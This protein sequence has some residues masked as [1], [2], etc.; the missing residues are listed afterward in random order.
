M[1][2]KVREHI[3]RGGWRIAV[4]LTCS[5]VLLGVGHGP[6][7]ASSSNVTAVQGSA[8]GY[9]A[10]NIVLL[11]GSQSDT[12]PT[13]SVTLAANASN[14]PQSASATTGLVAY[15]PATL[16]TSDGISM[17]ATGSLG[18]S[19]FAAT[20][21]DINNINQ[22]TT[23]SSTGS[24]ILTADELD[25]DCSATTSGNTGLTTVIDGKLQTDSGWD[26]GD[27]IPNES[28]ANAGGTAEHP[29][30]VVSL[31]DTTPAINDTRTGHIHL[32]GTTQDDFTVVFNEQTTT[33]GVLTVTGAHE[34]FEGPSLTGDLF[35]GQ[36][37][38]GVTH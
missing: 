35:I 28:A 21:T 34:Y 31:T 38:C 16:F 10:D 12:G 30:V 15:G 26:D 17:S 4:V 25:T 11:G 1:I 20:S 13:P 33:N 19:G 5:A 6:A 24:E 18:T 7:L 32:S 8:F 36:A 37:V 22:A 3:R 27:G 2:N 23:Q 29:P 14:S 9:H